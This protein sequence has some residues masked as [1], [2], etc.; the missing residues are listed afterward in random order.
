MFDC[1]PFSSSERG[2]VIKIAVRLVS[3]NVV[4]EYECRPMMRSEV[5]AN[6]G[7]SVFWNRFFLDEDFGRGLYVYYG[8]TVFILTR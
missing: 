8:F 5:T 4:V 2:P 1:F 3:G 7:F 6:I